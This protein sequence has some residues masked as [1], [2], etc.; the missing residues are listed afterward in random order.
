MKLDETN[1]VKENGNPVK[2]HICD[3]RLGVI[4]GASL[5]FPKCGSSHKNSIFLFSR[6]N[7]MFM[8]NKVLFD[9]LPS[10]DLNYIFFLL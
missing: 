1:K 2:R 5:W 8:E 4:H 3:S 7:K 6:F 10:P 9:G